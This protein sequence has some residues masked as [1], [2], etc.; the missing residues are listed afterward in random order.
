MH[1]A[2]VL[3]PTGNLGDTDGEDSK[4]E[5]SEVDVR[6]SKKRRVISATP[7]NS[8]VSGPSLST[9]LDTW[10]SQP[11]DEDELR[12]YEEQASQLQ[13]N[14]KS[15]PEREKAQLGESQEPQPEPD[16]T[17]WGEKL[18]VCSSQQPGEPPVVLYCFE[19]LRPSDEDEGENIGGE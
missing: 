3:T 17:A 5:A 13:K 11:R 14:T 15:T 18:G 10:Q 4:S 6:P 9:F 1:F 8:P 2:Y 7:P 12:I 16:P 19:D